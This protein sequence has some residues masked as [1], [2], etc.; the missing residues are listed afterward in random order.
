MDEKTRC[1]GDSEIYIDYHDN[2]WG[3]PVH[4]DNPDQSRFQAYYEYTKSMF[5]VLEFDVE[6]MLIVTGTRSEQA[7]ANAE[8]RD[9]LRSAGRK[10]ASRTSG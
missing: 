4:D 10:L 1:F 8:L 5:Q 3:R 7:N 6:D 2:E 9:V